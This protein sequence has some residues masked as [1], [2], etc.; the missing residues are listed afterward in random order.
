M[1]AEVSS[2][3]WILIKATT[4]SNLEVQDTGN[5]P[6]DHDE[7]DGSDDHDDHDNSEDSESDER[8]IP[9]NRH[10]EKQLGH[11]PPLPLAVGY[12][13]NNRWPTVRG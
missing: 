11:E 1:R 3:V 12:I 13:P 9:V 8:Q 5:D 2:S 7:Y 4:M 6:D 10:P